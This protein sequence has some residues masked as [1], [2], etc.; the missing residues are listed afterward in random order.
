MKN[1]LTIFGT[2]LLILSM[3]LAGC[4]SSSPPSAA[5]TSGTAPIKI[6]HIVHVSGSA[7]EAGAAEKNGALLAVADA[8]NG[9]SDTRVGRIVSV[10]GDLF[11][12]LDVA[13]FKF[14]V[15]GFIPNDKVNF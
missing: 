7:V 1:R 10:C 8:R 4:G 13:G 14:Q 15:S 12:R 11:W 6:G 2:G 5:P 9:I 3:L